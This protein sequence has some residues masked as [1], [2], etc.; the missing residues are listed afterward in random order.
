MIVHATKVL[1]FTSGVREKSI[2][3]PRFSSFVQ[4]ADQCIENCAKQETAPGICG[5]PPLG[6]NPT[7]PLCTPGN[8]EI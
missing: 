2:L 6:I 1:F 8:E 3:I 7:R 4:G 5:R